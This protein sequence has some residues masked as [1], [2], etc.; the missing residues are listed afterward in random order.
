MRL[1]DIVAAL[2]RPSVEGVVDRPIQGVT[3]DSRAAGPLDLYVAIP[4][5]HVDGRRFVPGLK[6]AAVIAEGPVNAE[7][8]V[9]TI[10]VPDARRALALAAAALHGQPARHLPVVGITGTNGKTTTTWMLEGIARGAGL[11]CG[12]IGTIG[13]RIAGEAIP[14]R[15]TTPE[16]PAL[17]ALLARALDAGCAYVAME[18]SSI[19]IALERVAQI[20]F[21]VGIFTS[22]SQD[23][24]DFHK[25][26]ATYLAAKERL[27]TELMDP[28]GTAIL[29]G[30][31]PVVRA[32]RPRAARTWRTSVG[33]EGEIRALDARLD[34]KGAVARVET[35][36][37]AGTL[38]LRMPGLHNLQNALGAL[39]A[40]LAL[41][42][43]LEQV[44]G[45]LEAMDPVPGR[46]EPIENPLGITVLVDY[47]HT[48]DALA[49][50]LTTLRP[51]T[52]GRLLTLFGCGGD[53]DAEKRP[54]MGEAASAGS[55][56]VYLTSDNPRSE[57]PLAILAQILA[58]VR[59][60]RVVEPDRAR[61]IALVIADAQ[62][63]DLVLIAGKGHEST[64]TIGQI[65][66]PFS[67][68]AVARAALAARASSG[69]P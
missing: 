14:T 54:L 29:C 69:T 58:G 44:L 36:M 1:A 42:I 19:G 3:H 9:S 34:G 53:R 50:V 61:A 40:G 48:P 63:G 59:G 24:L 10:L 15:F 25:D 66:R 12:V 18:V 60:E 57:D 65:E 22:F 46:L 67:D 2:D 41:G 56:R 26:M 13:H 23:H 4:G 28:D 45:G 55:D 30:D 64:Q 32:I 31:D 43:P 68:A 52:R 21:R 8:G 39:G 7:A 6:V 17:Q 27:F 51:L 62:P 20:P 47:A 16:A 35:P 5:A 33:G 11:S 37:G 38:R 49:R